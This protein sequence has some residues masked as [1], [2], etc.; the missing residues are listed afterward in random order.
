MI[1]YPYSVGSY[2]DASYSDAITTDEIDST[3]TI[4]AMHD[5]NYTHLP[6]PPTADIEKCFKLNPSFLIKGEAE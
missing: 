5:Y 3:V 6:E 2:S 4:S 1:A